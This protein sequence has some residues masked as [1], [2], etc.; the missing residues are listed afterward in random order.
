MVLERLYQGLISPSSVA[1]SSWSQTRSQHSWLRSGLAAQDSRPVC[2]Q[3][4]SRDR[5]PDCSHGSLSTPEHPQ[6]P[7]ASVFP[8]RACLLN[9]VHCPLPANAPTCKAIFLSHSPLLR[10]R[11]FSQLCLLSPP[12]LQQ[13]KLEGQLQVLCSLAARRSPP[14][15][16]PKLVQA[17][18]FL[19]TPWVSFQ[20]IRH[21][22]SNRPTHSPI[23]TECCEKI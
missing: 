16:P 19:P 3:L 2:A 17:G 9:T 5:F 8:T 20:W 11:N 23:P 4:A 1:L 13:L 12:V 18:V 7:A 22:N 6:V 15:G 21:R 10:A 14:N